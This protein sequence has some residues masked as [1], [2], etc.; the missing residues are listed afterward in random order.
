MKIREFNVGD[1]FTVVDLLSSIAG[2][3]G[4]DLRNILRSGSSNKDISE[5]EAE[6]RGVE[7]C[8]YVLNKSYLGCKEKLISWF[9]SLVDMS[10]GDFLRQPPET[11]LDI[12]EEI[13]KRKESKDFF[14]RACRLLPATGNS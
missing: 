2:S 12:I 8:L 7:I 1:V 13:S 10:I 3:A 9:S 6:D 5:S 4:N 14:S 11:I